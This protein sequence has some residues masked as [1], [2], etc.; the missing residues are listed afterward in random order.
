MVKYDGVLCLV[1]SKRTTISL[2]EDYN[3]RFKLIAKKEYSD[4]S[5]LVRKWIDENFK[6]EYEINGKE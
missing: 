6:P 2:D 1:M 4:Q 3:R 5:K